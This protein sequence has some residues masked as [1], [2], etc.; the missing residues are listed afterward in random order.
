M[1]AVLKYQPKR[2]IELPTVGPLS[3]LVVVL[4]RPLRRACAVQEFLPRRLATEL[5]LRD[6]PLGGDSAADAQ[7]ALI[8]IIILF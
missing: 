3:R 6:G 2:S 8:F 4:L 7:D 1:L 5:R